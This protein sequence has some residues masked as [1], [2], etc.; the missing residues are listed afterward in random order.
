[1]ALPSSGTISL[2]QMNQEFGLGYGFNSYRGKGSVPATGQIWFSLM[3]GAT[4]VVREPASGEYYSQANPYY[5]WTV[6]VQELAGT[7][8]ITFNSDGAQFNNERGFT[9][10]A[11]ASAPTLTSLSNYGKTYYRGSNKGGSNYAIYRTTP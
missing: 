7:I 3:Y 2:W 1:M 8:S 4:A 11:G 5:F 9:Y 6:N 10:N